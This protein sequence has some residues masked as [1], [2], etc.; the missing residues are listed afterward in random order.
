MGAKTAIAW[1]DHTFNAWRG[2]SKVSAGCANCYAE[3]MSKRNPAVFGTWGGAGNRIVAAESGWRLPLVWDTK[4]ESVE[5]YCA[6]DPECNAEYG[7]YVRPRVFCGSLMDFFE[8]RPDL[9]DVR[10][11]ALDT[12]R[13]TQHLDWLIL[14]KRPE[15]WAKVLLA[16]IARMRERS[17]R[18]CI[19]PSLPNRHDWEYHT[20]TFVNG[21]LHGEFRGA[22]HV[23]PPNIWLGVSVEDQA[24]ADERIPR[25]LNIPAAV[26]FLSCEPLLGP[27]DLHSVFNRWCSAHEGTAAATWPRLRDFLHWVIVGG[28]SGPGARECDPAWIASIVGQ[29]LKA[30]VA[31]FVKQDSGPRPGEQG[32]I[33]DGLWTFK[34]F[35]ER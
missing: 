35:P 22:G 17:G 7:P 25:L 18:K 27:I 32:R 33:P 29:C 11:R 28:E 31:V 19:F 1:C 34:R 26:R 3:R 14:T 4:A 15:N 21:W 30:G 2:C 13:Q 10:I 8:D 6:G 20:P 23:V 16:T 12:I 9:L 24:A 5:R